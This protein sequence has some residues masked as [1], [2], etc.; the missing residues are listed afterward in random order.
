MSAV[1]RAGAMH[2]TH[3]AIKMVLDRLTHRVVGVSMLGVNAGEVLHKVLLSITGEEKKLVQRYLYNGS[4][5]RS[6]KSYFTLAVKLR[7]SDQGN[8]FL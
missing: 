8:F 2:G 1:P 7:K 3:G 4:R 6:T 5:L